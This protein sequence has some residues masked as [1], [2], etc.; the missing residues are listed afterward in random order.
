MLSWFTKLAEWV[1]VGYRRRLDRL[2][3]DLGSIGP[4]S[5]GRGRGKRGKHE[6][7]TPTMCGKAPQIERLTSWLL[8]PSCCCPTAR[9]AFHIPSTTTQQQNFYKGGEVCSRILLIRRKPTYRWKFVTYYTLWFR[10]RHFSRTIDRRAYRKASVSIFLLQRNI[11][12]G[13]MISCSRPY[14]Q[15]QRCLQLPET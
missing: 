15:M 7:I 3:I 4:V 13:I 12:L 14:H 8:A 11:R 6:R 9:L 1:R 2:S 10:N 5:H